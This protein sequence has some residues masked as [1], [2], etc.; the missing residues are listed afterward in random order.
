[1]VKGK[2]FRLTSATLGIEAVDGQHRPITLPSDAIV[3]LVSAPT[4]GDR[5]VEIL[6]NKRPLLIF[7]QDIRSRG[8]EV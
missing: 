3:E 8:E 1:M 5:L 6:W 4:D 2:R 7:T